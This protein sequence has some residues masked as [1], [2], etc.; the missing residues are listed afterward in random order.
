MEKK[1]AFLILQ[2]PASKKPIV[3]ILFSTRAN[4]KDFFRGFRYGIANQFEEFTSSNSFFNRGVR[5]VSLWIIFARRWNLP[6]C[7]FVELSE[8]IEERPV[9]KNL[10]NFQRVQIVFDKRKRIRKALL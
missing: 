5:F 9:R 8:D 1:T 2:T 10:S 3:K 6:E 7:P 4:A